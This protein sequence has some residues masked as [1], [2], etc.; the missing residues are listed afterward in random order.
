M[1]KLFTLLMI[2]SFMMMSSQTNAQCAAP[3]NLAASYSNNVSHFSWDIVPTATEYYFEIDWAGSQWG[4]GSITVTDPFYDMTGL[5]QGGNFQWRVTA[6]CSTPSATQFYNTPCV[7]PLNLTTTN[8]TTNSAKLNW[9]QGIDNPNNT[10][11]SVSYRLANT[12]NA[13]IQ[14]TNIYNNPTATFFNLTGLTP[15]TAYEWRVKRVCSAYPSDYVYSSFVTLSCISNGSNTSEWIDLFALGTINRVSG[16]EPGGYANTALST[17]LVIGSN[18]NAGQISAGYA[19]S[20]SSERF[21]VYIDFNRNG[22][23]ADAGERLINASNMNNAGIKNFSI[24][25]PAT[26]TAGPTRMRVIMRRSSGSITPCI[27]GYLGETEDYNV[28]LVTGTNQFVGNKEIKPAAVANVKTLAIAPG[29]V[30]VSPN[31]SNGIFTVTLAKPTASA[32]YEIVNMNGAAVQ[33]NSIQNTAVIKIN[34]SQQPAGVYI[35][36]ITNKDGKQFLQKL[37]KL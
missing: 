21:S 29:L 15:G 30:S 24:N 32:T 13:W 31:P 5:M 8:I 1:K 9:Q 27:T 37:Q 7:A 14:L 25:I 17:N 19:S 33:K 16:A 34:I 3:T 12:N 2:A 26:A 23:F 22:S 28:N 36:R 35:L 18:S 11:F 20:V 6:N 4:F 10:G